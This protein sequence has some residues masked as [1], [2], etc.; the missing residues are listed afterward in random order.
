M[1]TAVGTASIL[2]TIT[3]AMGFTGHAVRGDFNPHLAIPLA[4]IAVIGG[5]IGSKLA[6]Q[7][8]PKNLKKLFA[9]SNWI[10]ALFMIFN[11]LHTG[12]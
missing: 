10:A 4:V 6:L 2:I 11:A 3:A 5:I 9:Y 8:R 7:S 1:Y 12:G